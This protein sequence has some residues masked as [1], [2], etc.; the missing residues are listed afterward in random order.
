MTWNEFGGI[1]EVFYTNDHK[2]GFQKVGSIWRLYGSDGEFIQNFRSFVL[3][4]KYIM[5][6]R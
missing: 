3:M 5:E 6:H 1:S 4:N 2:F